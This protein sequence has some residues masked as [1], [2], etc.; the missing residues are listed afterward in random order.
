MGSIKPFAR[1]KLIVGI[2]LN[3][4]HV[5]WNEVRTLLVERFGDPDLE[6]G[7]IDFTF[8]Q[9]Y[10]QEMG[11]SLKRYFL[12]FTSLVDP[13]ELPAIKIF[14][15]NLEDSRFSKEG[16]RFVN[17]DP[18][19][20]SPPHL[21]LATTKNFS[22]RVPLKDGIYGEVT[23]FYRHHQWEFLPWTYPDFKSAEY[24]NFLSKAR[25]L[26]H[27]QTHPESRSPAK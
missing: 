18:G 7:P 12:S 16:N 10:R 27:L 22:H 11:E 26:L 13:T 6:A 2:L 14:T 5:T 25:E 15:N 8:T 1:E 20:V 9:Y 24:L 17:M 21:I 4:Q 3:P 23:L 19:L